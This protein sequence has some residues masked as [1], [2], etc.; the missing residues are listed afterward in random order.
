MASL[1]SQHGRNATGIFNVQ[2]KDSEEGHR[3]DGSK[4]KN[5]YN[6]T[7]NFTN[8]ATKDT[9]CDRKQSIEMDFQVRFKELTSSPNI[10]MEDY[11]SSLC[12]K[13]SIEIAAERFNQSPLRASRESWK[14][15]FM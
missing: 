15:S 4:S 9:N 11:C 10:E 7:I 2:D 1:K 14:S 6:G 5:Q 8:K 3:Y 12:R 13:R